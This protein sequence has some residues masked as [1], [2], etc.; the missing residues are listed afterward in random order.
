[1]DTFNVNLNNFQSISGAELEF[2]EGLNLIVGQS[3]SGKT[4]ILRAI[5]SVVDNPSR[6]KL[7][8]K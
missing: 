8:I 1:M 7:Y 4:A 2:V 5:N 6:G 3:N